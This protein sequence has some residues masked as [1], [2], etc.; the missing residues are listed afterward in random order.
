MLRTPMKRKRTSSVSTQRKRPRVAVKS[1]QLSS[2]EISYTTVVSGAPGP[3]TPLWGGITSSFTTALV[4]GTSGKNA[5]TGLRI[6]PVGMT[7]HLNIFRA[8]TSD[9]VRFIV[10]QCKLGVVPTAAQLL[11]Q[12]ANRFAPLS[13][14]NRDYKNHYRVLKDNVYKLDDLSNTAMV[15]K[16]YIKGKKLKQIT[17]LAAG[18]VST[19]D[20]IYY[21]YGT[22]AGGTV[23]GTAT[24]LW[25]TEI[26]YND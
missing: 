21:A 7:V 12:T 14:Y 19:G 6:N 23:T 24:M 1:N 3:V 22:S 9:V 16:I 5:Y 26:V 25:H 15:D 11:D 8:S 20:I 2:A 13:T 17:F 10:I 4:G 18:G